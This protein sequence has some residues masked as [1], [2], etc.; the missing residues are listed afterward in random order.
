MCD[1]DHAQLLALEVDHV[2]LQRLRDHGGLVDVVSK[3]R[4]PL[5]LLLGHRGL[6]VGDHRGGCN[7]PRTWE[8]LLQLADPEEVIEV[9]MRDVDRRQPLAGLLDHVAECAHLGLDARASRH[10]ISPGCPSRTPT[11]HFGIRED[12]S[13]GVPPSFFPALQSYRRLPAQGLGRPAVWWAA[14]HDRVT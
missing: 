1:L 10:I 4:L 6:D 5:L 11:A 3:P 14:H 2:A 12:P 7:R 13:C 8:S 9:P